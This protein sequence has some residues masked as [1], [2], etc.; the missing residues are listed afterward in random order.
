MKYSGTF[1]NYQIKTTNHNLFTIITIYKLVT[2]LNYVL[3]YCVDTSQKIITIQYN[4][5][6]A[7]IVLQLLSILMIRN[8]IILYLAIANSVCILCNS[9]RHQS[10]SCN[11][12]NNSIY[13]TIVYYTLKS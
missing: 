3:V 13:S 6:T 5:R 8:T 11:I 10:Q 1:C 2:I 4:L 7:R 9:K 12:I